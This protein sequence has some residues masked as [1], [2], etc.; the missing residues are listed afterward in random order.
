[1]CPSS[2]AR[3]NRPP[4][5]GISEVAV[6]SMALSDGI[7]TKATRIPLE[8]EEDRRTRERQRVRAAQEGNLMAFEEA[9]SR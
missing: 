9:L 7:N 4:L 2:P 1:M 5:T 8:T 6:G 3:S